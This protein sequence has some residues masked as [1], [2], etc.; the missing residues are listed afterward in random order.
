MLEF[1]KIFSE[2][3]IYNTQTTTATGQRPQRN[4][5]RIDTEHKYMS[6]EKIKDGIVVNLYAVKLNGRSANAT[7]V[8][9]E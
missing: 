1:R 2:A 5:Q 3:M 9:R 6:V 7:I 8:K 4:I